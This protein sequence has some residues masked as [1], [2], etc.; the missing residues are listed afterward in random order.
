MFR[1]LRFFQSIKFF[2]I[3][4]FFFA[5]VFGAVAWLIYMQQV[6]IFEETTRMQVQTLPAIIQLQRKGR[7]FEQIRNAG[8]QFMTAA[9]QEKRQN[10]LLIL[11]LMTEHPSIQDD[12]DNDQVTDRAARLLA[13]ANL[14]MIQDPS[15]VLLWQQRWQ[16]VALQLSESADEAMTSAA[17]LM[18]Q[19]VAGLTA[20]ASYVR[21]KLLLTMFIAGLFILVFSWLLQRHVLRPLMQIHKALDGLKS[22]ES[23]SYLQHSSMF[24]IQ[25]IETAVTDLYELKKENEKVHQ[26]LIYQANHDMLTGLPNRRSFIQKAERAV[27]RVLHDGRAATV[28]MVDVD[29]FKRINDKFSH[30]TGDEVLRQFARILEK[31]FR[32]EDL[33]CRYGGEEFAFLVIDR[34]PE[35]SKNLAERL[36]LT[37]A[38]HLFQTPDGHALPPISVSIG[39]AG[40]TQEGFI[41]AIEN[42]DSALYVAKGAG[43]NQTR[44]TP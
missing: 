1:F 27:A 36:R 15:S 16:P 35:E 33:I 32:P 41:K 7:N 9:T 5:I 6:Q 19:E 39:L 26:S 4:V 22:S 34:D 18:T 14:A 23:P 11:T 30:A 43:R 21:Y 40:I 13:A 37:V 42:A 31:S 24:E 28:G 20:A 3:L 25:A 17:Q 8:D 2:S 29:F 44:V 10:A 38:G 12:R